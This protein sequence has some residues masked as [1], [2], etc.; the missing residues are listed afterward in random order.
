M[1][2][3]YAGLPKAMAPQLKEPAF[4]MQDI[5]FGGYF[6]DKWT[7]RGDAKA[8]DDALELLQGDA[9]T[10][11]RFAEDVFEQTLPLDAIAQVLH[12]GKLLKRLK[13]E[14]TLDEMQD[15]LEEIGVTA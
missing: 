2:T 15:D 5:S 7:L 14:R 10:Y 12:G 3:V 11:R 1:K 9:E 4:S 13:S 6:A 8:L